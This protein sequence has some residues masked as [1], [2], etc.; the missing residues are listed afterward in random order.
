M[1]PLHSVPPPS[2][3]DGMMTELRAVLASG[4]VGEGPKVAAFEEALRGVVRS[5]H[6]TAV[7]SGT[8]ALT[9]A[10]RLA[11]VGP[12]DEVITTPV[13]CM[14]TNL[15]ILLAGATPV[16]AD[17]DPSTG[18]IDPESIRPTEKTKAIMVVHWG[19]YPCD[20][21]EIN[22]IGRSHGIKVIEDAAHALGATYRDRPIGSHS[23]FVCFSFQAIKHIHTGDGG[24]LCCRSMVDHS[25]ARSLKWFGIDR[26]RR[27]IGLY[28]IAEWEVTE[29]GYKAHMNDISATIGLSLLPGLPAILKA[30][31]ANA[32]AYREAFTGLKR[33][34]PLHEQSDRQSANWLFTLRVDDQISFIR[35]LRGRGIDS[36]IVHARNDLA[37][38]FSGMSNVFLP[39]VSRFAR[40]MVCI[41]VGQ[42]LTEG[43][44]RQ[45]V[46]AVTSEAW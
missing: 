24:L 12:G 40:S 29:A 41:P 5:D 4:W 20:M 45:I 32:K 25:R 27:Q 10:L 1:I 30:R 2:D 9:I 15:P 26:E 34:A 36:S 28:G 11:G 43:T 6:V 21:D 7:N 14:A 3:L 33:V 18:N 23:D 31:A 38:V 35:Y 8:A 19:G 13:T 17:V 22:A 37:P 46:E 44:R 42:W 16:W 39:G